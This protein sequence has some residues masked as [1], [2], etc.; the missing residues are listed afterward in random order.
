MSV[1]V[2]DFNNKTSRLK[3]HRSNIVL[4]KFRMKE[5]SL[6]LNFLMNMI[7]TM[8]SFIFP[9]ITF[10]YISLHFVAYR[11]RKSFIA[12][13]IISYFSMFA[14]VGN[15]CIWNSCVCKSEG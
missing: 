4:G 5:K 7:L 11:N 2:P 3:I 8:S 10:P 13:S 1:R 6:K 15:S 14:A 12:T 9:L